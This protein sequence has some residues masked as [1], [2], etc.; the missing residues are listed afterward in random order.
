MSGLSPFCGDDDADTICNVL[1]VEFDFAAEEFDEITA[2]CKDFIKK[3]LIKDPRYADSNAIGIRGWG[4]LFIVRNL[5]VL[6]GK[7][8]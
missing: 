6:S 3:L 1:R 7:L 5:I 2:G 4:A 8:L